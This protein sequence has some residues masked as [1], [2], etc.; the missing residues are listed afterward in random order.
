MAIVAKFDESSSSVLN[1][2]KDWTLIINESMCRRRVFFCKSSDG[3]R[4]EFIGY[5]VSVTVTR[6]I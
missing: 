3:A 1:L 4:N 6:E 5:L 2:P